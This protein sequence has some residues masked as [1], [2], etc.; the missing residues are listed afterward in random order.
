M[1]LNTLLGKIDRSLVLKNKREI[2]Y[3]HI[4]I[5]SLIF[6]LSYTYLFE[7]SERM[8]ENNKNQISSLRNSIGNDKIYLQNNTKSELR[9][10]NKE[11][12]NLKHE[13]SDLVVEREY[14]E[15]ELSNISYLY[16]DEKVWGAFLDSIS[17]KAKDNRVKIIAIENKFV[18]ERSDFG[19]VLEIKIDVEGSFGNIIRF[20]N[21]VEKSDLVVDVFNLSLKRGATIDAS[22]EISVWGIN[23]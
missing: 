10:L 19:H 15:Y 12:A 6:Y 7:W 16:Y 3:I 8:F 14:I 18:K 13:A 11:I 2:L 9:K 20:L 22:F 5:V 21:S 17:K 23:R 1:T 4:T